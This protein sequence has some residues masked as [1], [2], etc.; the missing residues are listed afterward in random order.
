MARIVVELTN[1]CNLR[2]RHC[3][4][5]RHAGTAELSLDI[6][7]K[8]LREGKQCSIDHLSFTGGEPT[9]HREFEEVVKR[10]CDGGY[11]FSFVSNGSTLPKI[12][13]LLRKYR[14][15]F[16]GATF[17]LDG[18]RQQTHDQLRGKGSFREVM[19]AASVCMFNDL[20][21]SLNMVLTAHNRSQIGELIELAGKLG[22]QAVRFG[23]LMPTRDTA[24][25]GL[26]LTP[27]ERLQT[28][29]EIR[30][31]KKRSAVPVGI[32]AGH[33][34]ES[35]FFPCGPLELEEYNLDCEGNLTLCC[36]L[37]GYSGPK[38]GTDLMGNLHD[39][40]LA[41][42]CARFAE[43]VATYL[44]DKQDRVN[45]GEFEELD[46]FPCWYCVKY[47]DKVQALKQISGHPWINGED[48]S[49]QR[50]A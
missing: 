4:D 18:A 26:D 29:A 1:S 9:M 49:L 17:S 15:S 2:C 36:H 50:R 12:Y 43:R 11:T 37:S 10:V 24:L 21:F 46:H 14:Q 47:L 7:D 42:A 25:R 8:L 45:R 16:R 20:P 38:A 30:E 48:Q 32:A 5:P 13:P 41:A 39:M 3:Y 19:R 6:I 33:Y 44:A 28:E 22:S 35:P 23:H 31:L 40:T 34:S 27:Q